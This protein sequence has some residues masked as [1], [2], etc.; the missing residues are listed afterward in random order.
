ML[1]DSGVVDHEMLHS[2]LMDQQVWAPAPHFAKVSEGRVGPCVSRVGH[3]EARLGGERKTEGVRAVDSF[4]GGNTLQ[5]KLTNQLCHSVSIQQLDLPALLL[6]V[7][8]HHQMLALNQL[9]VTK[10]RLKPENQV[11]VI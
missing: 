3:F 8:V 9:G 10:N 11:K 4:A 1:L 6:P 5:S 7:V 2:G